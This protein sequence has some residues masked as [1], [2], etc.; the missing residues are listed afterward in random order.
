[1][2][3]EPSTQAKDTVPDKNQR[4]AAKVRALDDWDYFKEKKVKPKAGENLQQI[5]DI[6]TWASEDQPY[7]EELFRLY[8]EYQLRQK[9]TP[10]ELI[11]DIFKYEKE[12]NNIVFD[13][14]N[15]EEVRLKQETAGKYEM[16][17][18]NKMLLLK[19]TRELE[20][21]ETDIDSL[22]KL[23]LKNKELMAKRKAT[24]SS[25]TQL[26]KLKSAAMLRSATQVSQDYNNSSA[27]NT[28]LG[29]LIP[30]NMSRDSVEIAH[31]Q[32][33]EAETDIFE[34]DS[35]YLKLKIERSEADKK[36]RSKPHLISGIIEDQ[37]L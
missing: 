29:L 5:S 4:E 31:L 27:D 6:L 37:R 36:I 2:P 32:Q 20:D 24:L 12:K 33:N 21:Q 22:K 15:R 10:K 14:L 35:A 30:H 19:F 26:S 7:T 8:K 3:E 23:K 16:L 13:L 25:Q 1:M 11:K 34:S 9:I 18:T 17:H 28:E